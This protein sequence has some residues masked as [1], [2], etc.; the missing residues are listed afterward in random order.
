MPQSTKDLMPKLPEAT[1]DY[2]PIHLTCVR[3]GGTVGFI[4]AGWA[5]TG[6][7]AGDCR[8]CE[9]EV[10][11]DWRKPVQSDFNEPYCEACE[12]RPWYN[13][14]PEKLFTVPTKGFIEFDGLAFAD[15][16]E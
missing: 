6:Q 4:I 1:P 8:G 16:I 2:E 15:S 7:E 11:G 13:Q 3:C 9:P 12:A 5:R 10:Y 14:E